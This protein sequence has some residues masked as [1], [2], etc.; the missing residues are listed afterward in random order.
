[1]RSIWDGCGGM[2]F[3]VQVLPDASDRAVAPAIWAANLS[4]PS[5]CFR[6]RLLPY[7]LYNPQTYS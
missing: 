3:R 2:E 5:N 1:M 4:I 6:G 7:I